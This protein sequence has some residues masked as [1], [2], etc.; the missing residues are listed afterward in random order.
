LARTIG[1]FFYRYRSIFPIPFFILILYFGRLTTTSLIFGTIVVILGL[2]IRIWAAGYMR[3][4]TRYKQFAAR[5]LITSGPYRYSRHPLYI[6]NFLL[7]LGVLIL[8][9][10]GLLIT[11]I[12]MLLFIFEYYSIVTAEETFLMETMAPRYEEYMKSTSMLIGLRT[13]KNKTVRER[14]SPTDLL[15]EINTILLIAIAYFLIIY[16]PQLVKLIK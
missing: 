13:Y 6:A 16:K 15:K 1:N 2:L 4:E 12:I 7:T 8:Y 10:T 9:S 11:I 14:F 5:E 3:K